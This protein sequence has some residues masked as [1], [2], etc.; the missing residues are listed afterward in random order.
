MYRSWYLKVNYHDLTF[1]EPSPNFVFFV[2]G[3]TSI[4]IA[5]TNLEFWINLVRNGDFHHG[6]SS[7]IP[8]TAG[9]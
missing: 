4:K 8:G 9:S 2:Y 1:S 5:K 7:Q 3:G 6:N